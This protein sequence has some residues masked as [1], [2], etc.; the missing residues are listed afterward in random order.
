MLGCKGYLP[1]L[2]DLASSSKLLSYKTQWNSFRLGNLFSMT[3]KWYTLQAYQY[4]LF[5]CREWHLSWGFS[6]SDDHGGSRCYIYLGRL[7]VAGIGFGAELALVAVLTH[8]AHV[9]GLA[10]VGLSISTPSPLWHT[11]SYC[12]DDTCIYRL[13]MHVQ[14]ESLEKETSCSYKQQFLA[15]N[16]FD[17]NML[18]CKYLDYVNLLRVSSS[19]SE[20]FFCILF[21]S[22]EH[23]FIY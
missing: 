3:R 13:E 10:D 21:H 12:T 20:L 14:K 9:A 5:R 7:Q 4:K 6:F 2:L 17:A 16:K 23:I 11:L 22:F 1:V 8:G 15:T 18:N 19:S